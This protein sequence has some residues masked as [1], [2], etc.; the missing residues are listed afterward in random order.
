MALTRAEKQAYL[1]YAQSRYRW[2]KL[3]D[4]EPSRFLEEI[5][6]RFLEHLAPKMSRQMN[7]FVDED[8]F[9]SVPQDKIRFKKPVTRDF[10]RSKK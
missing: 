6:E 8:I 3:I 10:Q 5:D 1:S 9:G 4:C 7:K 2:G